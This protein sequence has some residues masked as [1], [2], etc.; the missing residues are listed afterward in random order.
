M[1]PILTAAAV[2]CLLVGLRRLIFRNVVQEKLEALSGR[3]APGVRTAL[4]AQAAAL[5]GRI[6]KAMQLFN[7]EQTDVLLRRA[8]R[9]FDLTG[10]QFCA[11]RLVIM[12]VG[13][14]AFGA[15][16][17]AGVVSPA[18]ALSGILVCAAAPGVWLG[19]AAD[20]ER[21]RTRRSFM[22]FVDRL[23][24]AAAVVP[25]PKAVE[26]SASGPGFAFEEIRRV[27]QNVRAGR[28]FDKAMDEL[29]QA[30]EIP[31]ADHLARC[32]RYAHRHG[33]SVSRALSELAQDMRRRREAEITAQAQ[34]AQSKITLPIVLC[35]LPA[36]AILLLGPIALSFSRSFGGGLP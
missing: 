3:A 28:P 13:A 4:R 36:A 23:S 15:A 20:R 7:V 6:P 34:K 1:T 22:L 10:A 21:R 33:V 9:P 35:T 16:S 11:L 26:W 29:A 25:L 14:S 30:L 8:G 19:R 31:E 24:V 17:L 18:A 2:F 5:Y 12:G 32:L 27:I